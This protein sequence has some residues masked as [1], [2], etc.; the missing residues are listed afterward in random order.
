MHWPHIT[1]DAVLFC[2]GLGLLVYEVVFRSTERPAL[3]V[4]LCGMMGLPA[5]LRLDE[6][7]RNGKEPS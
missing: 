7:R 3:L 4:V 2:G 6:K 1:R 5:F